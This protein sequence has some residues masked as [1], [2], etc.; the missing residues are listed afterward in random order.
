MKIISIDD[1][2]ERAGDNFAEVLN[3]DEDK[4]LVCWHVPGNEDERVW[5]TADEF[6]R[7]CGGE[8]CAEWVEGDGFYPDLAIFET[9]SERLTWKAQR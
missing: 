9:E 7:D 6:F 8:G 2:V 5:Q 4:I 1:C 3:F